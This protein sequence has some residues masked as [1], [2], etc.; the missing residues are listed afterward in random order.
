MLQLIS[1]AL[2]Y[3][4]LIISA[5]AM[6]EQVVDKN[7]SGADKKAVVMKVIKEA[8][9][10]FN[11]KLTPQIE[12]FLSQAIDMAV[13][14]LNLFGVF[15]PKDEVVDEV[16]IVSVETAHKAASVIKESPTEARLKELEALIRDE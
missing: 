9:A 15:K 5:I 4:P 16:G 7:T 3:L 12:L 8:L 2:R 11:V 13:S 1:F 14:I 10:S 6:V